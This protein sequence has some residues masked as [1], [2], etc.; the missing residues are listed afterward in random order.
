MSQLIE[1]PE[2]KVFRIQGP[3]CVRLGA[4]DSGFYLIEDAPD[5]PLGTETASTEKEPR[6]K[7]K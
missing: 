1:V 5:Q 3:C 2:G 7:R 4:H 6:N